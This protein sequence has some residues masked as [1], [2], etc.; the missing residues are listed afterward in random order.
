MTRQDVGP[1]NR[2]DL[3]ISLDDGP[4]PFSDLPVAFVQQLMG[5]C[6]PAIPISDLAIPVSDLAVAFAQQLAL[7]GELAIPISDA[8]VAFTNGHVKIRDLAVASDNG[9]FQRLCGTIKR[10]YSR[11][12]FPVLSHRLSADR[13]GT[14]KARR[15]F[16][17]C[18]PDRVKCVSVGFP[19]FSK[20]PAIQ[21]L[22]NRP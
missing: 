5:G 21:N 3:A 16:V 1:V 4:I 20:G 6:D 14:A 17:E 13:N 9:L 2:F 19:D 18:R 8:L 15:G 11:L 12:V 7:G 22:E 10:L